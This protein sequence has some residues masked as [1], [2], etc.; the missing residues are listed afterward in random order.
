M[1]REI[2]FALIKREK[3]RK[4]EGRFYLPLHLNMCSLPKTSMTYFAT[5]AEESS[6]VFFLLNCLKLA[7]N[8]T[9]VFVCKYLFSKSSYISE[10]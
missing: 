7:M 10:I 4:K 5:I 1:K 9:Y 6:W 8:A 3:D 2:S